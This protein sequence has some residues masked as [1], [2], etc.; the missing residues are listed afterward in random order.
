MAVLA[1]VV[2][3]CSTG[4]PKG[5]R[6]V[7]GFDVKRYTGKWYEIARLDHPFER[8]LTHVTAEYAANS[9][10]TIKVTNRGYSEARKAWSEAVGEAR[11]SGAA[12]VAQLEVSLFGPFYGGYNVIALDENYQHALVAGSDRSYLWILA[13]HPQIADAVRDELVARAESLGFPT[14]ELIF[15][16]HAGRVPADG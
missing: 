6:P 12:S 3:S 1:I 7:T 13:R 5:V 4:A 11:F 15:V 16:D 14:D 10:G 8:G 9:D 2:G